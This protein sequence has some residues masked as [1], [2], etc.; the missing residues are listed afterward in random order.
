MLV[1]IDLPLLLP[2]VEEIRERLLEL[3]NGG[4]QKVVFTAPGLD[5]AGLQLVVALRKEF[6]WVEVELPPVGPGEVF[7]SLLAK[8]V[9][10]DVQD[11]GS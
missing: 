6:P 10:P 1:E 7:R 11:H 2:H 8:E 5:A 9:I 4:A 3:V